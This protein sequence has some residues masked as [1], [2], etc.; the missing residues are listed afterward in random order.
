M[1]PRT[2]VTKTVEGYQARYF[3]QDMRLWF[4]IG[5]PQGDRAEA[6]KRRLAWIERQRQKGQAT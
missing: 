6:E 4:D 2:A 3:D 5:D 1:K